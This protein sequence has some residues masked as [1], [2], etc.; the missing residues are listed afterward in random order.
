MRRAE[1]LM[2]GEGLKA[3]FRFGTDGFGRFGIHLRVI[4]LTCDNSY[5]CTFPV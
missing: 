2:E 3:A 4:M 5:V 1:W